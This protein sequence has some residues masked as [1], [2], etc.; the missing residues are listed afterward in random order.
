MHSDDENDMIKCSVLPTSNQD[1]DCAIMV[2]RIF[3]I[4]KPVFFNV[5]LDF[6][7]CD[8]FFDVIGMRLF[9]LILQIRDFSLIQ[10]KMSKHMRSLGKKIK[11]KKKVEDKDQDSA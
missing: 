4:F 11:G 7:C 2:N 1:Q 5:I 10:N 8:F 6:Q 9:H 3:V